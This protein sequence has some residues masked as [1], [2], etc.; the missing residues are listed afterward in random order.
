MEAPDE[1]RATAKSMQPRLR[2]RAATVGERLV[3]EIEDDGRGID[4]EALRSIGQQKGMP[5]NS[6]T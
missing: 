4:W 5:C 6:P 2:L 1:R 3:I